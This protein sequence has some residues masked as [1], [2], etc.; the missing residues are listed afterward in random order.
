MAF[1]WSFWWPVSIYLKTPLSYD[2]ALHAFGY[3]NENLPRV[4]LWDRTDLELSDPLA[5]NLAI[6]SWSWAACERE[7]HREDHGEDLG[8]SITYDQ[9]IFAFIADKHF[10]TLDAYKPPSTGGESTLFENRVLRVC[11]ATIKATLYYYLITRERT[12]GDIGRHMLKL[13]PRFRALRVII[14]C[15]ENCLQYSEHVCG[16][17][18]Q[19]WQ[20]EL[21]GL[22]HRRDLALVL[23]TTASGQ[24]ERI[25]LC[26]NVL[27]KNSFK[28]APER[29]LELV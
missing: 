26:Q 18:I 5:R 2:G 3:E 19:G 6:P 16:D 15:N 20:T 21:P 1:I 27:L 10:R 24:Y 25:T 8:T 11:G 14:I 28:R 29:A 4:L 17:S 23:W 7:V 22:P 13:S 9:A 12:L